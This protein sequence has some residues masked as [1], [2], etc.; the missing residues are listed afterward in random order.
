MCV[1][2]DTCKHIPCTHKNV[3][4]TQSREDISTIGGFSKLCTRNCTKNTQSRYKSWKIFIFSVYLDVLG[5]R[6]SNWNYFY[7]VYLVEIV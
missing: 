1:S 2:I 3:Y 6:V 4:L 5:N 7:Q